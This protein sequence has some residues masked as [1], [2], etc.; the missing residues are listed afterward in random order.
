MKVLA[1]EKVSGPIISDLTT[2][3]VTGYYQVSNGIQWDFFPLF[4]QL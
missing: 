2:T 4:S 3:D 1:F